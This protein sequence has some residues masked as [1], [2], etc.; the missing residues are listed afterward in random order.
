M[1]LNAYLT[2]KGQKQGAINGSVVQKGREGS[3]LVHAFNHEV[4]SPRDASSGLATGKRMH[5][6]FTITK[7]IDKSSPLLWNVLVTNENLAAWTLHCWTPSIASA[8]GSGVEKQSYTITLTNANIASI[9]EMMP[10]NQNPTLQNLSL[11][12]EITFTYQKISWTWVDG[13]ITAQDDWES[14]F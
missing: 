9:R 12:E 6:P 8:V 3:I 10:D 1:A 7:D 11:R 2:L 14:R 5:K 13:G 4:V